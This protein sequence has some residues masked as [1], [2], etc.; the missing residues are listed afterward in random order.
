MTTF[1]TILANLWQENSWK[2]TL[3]MSFVAGYFLG[4]MYV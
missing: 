3:L 4:Y 1:M 2:L